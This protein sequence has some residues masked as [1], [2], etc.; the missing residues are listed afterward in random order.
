MSALFPT[1][2]P[3]LLQC[4]ASQGLQRQLS[5]LQCALELAD[6]LSLLYSQYS[7]T[8]TACSR[9]HGDRCLTFVMPGASGS[10]SSSSCTGSMMM[11]RPYSIVAVAPS[12]STTIT[13]Q[14]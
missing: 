8:Q 3:S 7:R 14:P 10:I 6:E 11:L 13:N 12:I 9:G 5:D 4:C 1:S 2:Q